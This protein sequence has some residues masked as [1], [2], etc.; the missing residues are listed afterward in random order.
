M[1]HTSLREFSKV[2]LTLLKERGK[3]EVIVDDRIRILP[4]DGLVVGCVEHTRGKEHD[5][6]IFAE[7]NRQTFHLTDDKVVHV[8][9]KIEVCV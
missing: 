3:N 4:F 8:V 9:G 5:V 7:G 1:K 6:G 2:F